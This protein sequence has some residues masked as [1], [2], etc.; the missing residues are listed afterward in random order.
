MKINLPKFE[1]EAVNASVVKFSG[2]KQFPVYAFE[3]DEDVVFLVRARVK[4]VSHLERAKVGLAREHSMEIIDLVVPTQDKALEDLMDLK[5]RFEEE[6]E[7]I[8]HLP[9]AKNGDDDDG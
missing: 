9:L 1:R 8:A 2:S 3:H 6:H 4:G 7:G 5:D